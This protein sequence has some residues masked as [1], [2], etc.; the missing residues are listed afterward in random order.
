[1]AKGKKKGG[2]KKGKKGKKDAEDDAPVPD[3]IP[4]EQTSALMVYLTIESRKRSIAFYRT[5]CNQQRDLLKQH[6][7][8]LEHIG[9]SEYVTVKRMGSSEKDMETAI[10]AMRGEARLLK[11]L[12]ERELAAPRPAFKTAP[13][14]SVAAG[15]GA[16]SNGD[17]DAG[18]GGVP[19]FVVTG[20]TVVRD[21]AARAVLENDGVPLNELK[22][23]FGSELPILLGAERA[24]GM[25]ASNMGIP[26]A[27]F[28]KSAAHAKSPHM[29]KHHEEEDMSLLAMQRMQINELYS[30]VDKMEDELDVCTL[31]IQDLQDFEL[32]GGSS[33]LEA[34]AAALKKTAKGRID[35]RLQ[36]MEKI[37]ARHDASIQATEK[38]TQALIA[39]L[40]QRANQ[41]GLTALAGAGSDKARVL[42]RNRTLHAKVRLLQTE[43]RALV[44]R[45]DALEQENMQLVNR[46]YDLDWNLMYGSEE[47]L[48]LRPAVS[49]EPLTGQEGWNGREEPLTELQSVAGIMFRK[50]Q[51]FHLPIDSIQEAVRTVFDKETEWQTEH[52]HRANS[53]NSPPADNEVPPVPTTPTRIP[54]LVIP[55]N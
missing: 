26:L 46:S 31:K 45:V 23:V 7:A 25:E 8:R 2:V 52:L 53:H 12:K 34:E 10:D 49:D 47:S 16:D 54:P 37:Q 30:Y 36:Q 29:T 6:R 35:E 3:A 24:E 18:G 55:Q 41:Q 4:M 15:S 44:E 13:L 43:W 27:P 33:I 32:T 20:T 40:E 51:P 39:H 19:V 5:W 11:G 48:A 9:K 28:P 50:R 1:M 17:G 38:R 42:S 22:T 14:F 21:R